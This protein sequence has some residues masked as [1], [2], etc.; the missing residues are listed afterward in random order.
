MQD[1]EFW[2]VHVLALDGKKNLQNIE[3]EKPKKICRPTFDL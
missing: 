1:E 3:F 2:P